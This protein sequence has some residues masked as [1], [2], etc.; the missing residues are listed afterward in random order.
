MKSFEFF[1]M[2][3]PSVRGFIVFITRKSEVQDKHK[4]SKYTS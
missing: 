4:E 1:I 3:G 2:K